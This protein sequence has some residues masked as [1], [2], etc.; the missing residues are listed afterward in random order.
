[1]SEEQEQLIYFAGQKPSKIYQL[2]LFKWGK[3]PCQANA[4]DRQKHS[5]CKTLLPNAIRGR[6]PPFF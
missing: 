3:M 6:M 4:E 2:L 5:T 1:M